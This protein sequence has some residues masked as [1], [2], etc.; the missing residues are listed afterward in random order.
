MSVVFF[1]DPNTS[2]DSNMGKAK[3]LMPWSNEVSIRFRGWP[4]TEAMRALLTTV[5]FSESS[6]QRFQST[7]DSDIYMYVFG[8]N[9]GSM[10]LTGMAFL[11][12]CTDTPV[13][14]PTGTFA[15]QWDEHGMSRVLRFY[16]ESKVSSVPAQMELT[17]QPGI[18]LQAYMTGL[19]GQM[20]NTEQQ[21]FQFVLSF[22]LIP[23]DSRAQKRQRF[24]RQQGLS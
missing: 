13:D 11:D 20:I 21:L 7:L 5:D 19:R 1:T 16:R 23:G 24:Q 4:G 18:S 9:M 12:V 2:R 15:P 22:A 6:R 10:S 14:G 8:D 3:M 17:F